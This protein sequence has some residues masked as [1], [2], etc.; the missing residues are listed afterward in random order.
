MQYIFVIIES[1]VSQ[2]CLTL[3]DPMNCSLPR[4]SIHGIF[5][6]E[7]WS[8]V[9][10]PSPEDLPDPRMEPGPPALYADALLSEPPGK[11]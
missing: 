5:Q 3:C 10:F 11:S 2:A 8:G 1:L 4:P 9:P 7:Y 6:Q